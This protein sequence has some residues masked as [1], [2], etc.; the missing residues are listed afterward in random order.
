MEWRKAVLQHAHLLPGDGAARVAAAMS[1]LGRGDESFEQ[2]GE[3]GADACS[4]EFADSSAH[5][6]SADR[7][8]QLE[9]DIT[10]LACSAQTRF[11]ELAAELGVSK[12]EFAFKPSSQP[13]KWFNDPEERTIEQLRQ[14]VVQLTLFTSRPSL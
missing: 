1:C 11:E 8:A 9:Q 10:K 12:T 3:G 13:T 5:A 7:L 4:A 2:R 14:H 6:P